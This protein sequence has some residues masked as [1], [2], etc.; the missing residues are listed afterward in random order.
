[1]SVVCLKYISIG[2]GSGELNDAAL[3][4]LHGAVPPTNYTPTDS[5]VRGQLAGIDA[6]LGSLAGGGLVQTGAV[7]P[8]SVVTAAFRG[9]LYINTATNSQWVATTPTNSGWRQVVN[10]ALTGT[11]SP[12]GSATPRH[13]GDLYIDTTT[14]S[15]WHSY[16]VLN[17]EWEQ[18]AS[19]IITGVVSPYG[20]VV[21]DHE[22]QVYVDTLLGRVWFAHGSTSTDWSF[23]AKRVAGGI[24]VHE[25][26]DIP[27]GTGNIVLGGRGPQTFV[28]NNDAV[29]LGGNGGVVDGSDGAVALGGTSVAAIDAPNAI[30]GGSASLAN[31]GNSLVVGDSAAAYQGG[32]GRSGAVA[33]G[34]GSTVFGASAASLNGGV[35]YGDN[36]LAAGSGVIALADKA[37]AV[38]GAHGGVDTLVGGECALAVGRAN[39]VHGLASAAL[40]EHLRVGELLDRAVSLANVGADLELTVAGENLT[41][42]ITAGSYLWLY[43]LSGGGH[44][45]RTDTNRYRLLV[46]SVAFSGG[47]TV[48]TV[49][50]INIS[51]A[52]AGR[53]AL[54]DQATHSLAAGYRN[55]V[56]RSYAQSFG[57]D[58]VARN[59]GEF[60]R[61]GQAWGPATQSQ[62]RK[63]DLHRDVE[64]AAGTL[65]MYTDAVDAGT[66]EIATATGH[67]YAVSALVVGLIDDGGGARL[68]A[69][70]QMY[71]VFKNELGVLSQVGATAITP[72]ANDNP[73]RFDTDPAFD[74]NADNLRLEV[75]D[76]GDGSDTVRWMATVDMVELGI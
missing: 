76:D 70:W 74:V 23:A 56:A 73:L 7:D 65:Y 46:D 33:L 34:T 5:S 1:M 48:I 3:P 53:I 24:V 18:A 2:S 60:A 15:L 28:N 13:T 63:V 38:G 58:A 35:A 67:V 31:Q 8:N 40:G 4:S 72:L 52:T 29:L 41:S 54:V 10:P 66:E 17:T 55:R 44:D 20:V 71:G 51:P 9:Q 11:G 45:P 68:V 19:T 21:P 25:T 64:V 26:L 36:A 6:A 27:D 59:S 14:G 47:D 62:T 22:G 43:A 30:V 57:R 49:L 39:Q 42:V 50:T 61:A 32:D 69:A 12:I 75:A 16:G 37:T